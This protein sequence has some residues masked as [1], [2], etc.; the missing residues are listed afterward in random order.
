MQ[1]FTVEKNCPCPME[2]NTMSYS[3]SIVSTP[4]DP[5]DMCPSTLISN[6][7]LMSEFY[8]NKAPPQYIRNLI[9]FKENVSSSVEVYCR[10]NLQFRAEVRFRLATDSMSV[11]VMK[12]RLNFFDKLSTFGKLVINNDLNLNLNFF[13]RW[14]SG[15]VYRYEYTQYG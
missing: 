11:T 8:E 14:N 13:N 4:F 6:P 1:N 2:C 9:Q 10:K 7:F 12:R 15:I 5:K 3:F